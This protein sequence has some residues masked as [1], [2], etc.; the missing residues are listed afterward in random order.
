MTASSRWD[1]SGTF[2]L[3]AGNTVDPLVTASEGWIAGERPWAGVLLADPGFRAALG[4]RWRVLRAGGLVEALV[5]GVDR[6][7]ATLRRPAR[8]NFARWRTLED[9]VFRNQ[10]VHGSHPAAVA[11]LRDWLVRRAAWLDGALSP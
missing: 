2:D 6:R 11:A 4:A 8:R 10:P 5:R 7:A 9:R 3:S 1:P